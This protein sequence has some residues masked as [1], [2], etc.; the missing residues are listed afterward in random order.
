[1]NE[2]IVDALQAIFP[3]MTIINQKTYRNDRPTKVDV[4]VFTRHDLRY[5]RTLG[6]IKVKGGV[7][8]PKTQVIGGY[9]AARRFAVPDSTQC[10]FPCILFT[11]SSEATCQ[12][13]GACSVPTGGELRVAT[14]K[15]CPNFDLYSDFEKILR[16]LHSLILSFENSRDVKC[17]LPL[18]LQFKFRNTDKEEELVFTKH[19]R[20]TTYQATAGSQSV[21]VKFAPSGTT[22][23]SDVHDFCHKNGYAP[24]LYGVSTMG[25]EYT[26]VDVAVMPILSGQPLDQFVKGNVTTSEDKRKVLKEIKKCCQLLHSQKMVHGDLHPRN[27]LVRE[28]NKIALIDFEMSGLDGKKSYPE[29]LNMKEVWHEEVLRTNPPPLAV[30][31]DQYLLNEVIEPLLK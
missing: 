24:E 31:H 9:V 26:K 8:D 30:D 6:E 17:L 23:G 15:L 12:I 25:N 7:G 18:P 1:M 4:G 3:G 14:S 27:I 10:G 28:D 21:V 29:N 22:Y 16:R 5:A 2:S 19:I 13:Y 20:N 11:I